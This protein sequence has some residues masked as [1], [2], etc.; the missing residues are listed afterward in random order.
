MS[1]FA[2]RRLPLGSAELSAG[3]AATRQSLEHALV[4]DMAL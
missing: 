3:F 4:C 1:R 2:V